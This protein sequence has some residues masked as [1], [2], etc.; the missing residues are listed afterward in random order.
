MNLA[1]D[2][3]HHLS[4]KD[5]NANSNKSH[6]FDTLVKMFNGNIDS[7]FPN[8][9]KDDIAGSQI[10]LCVDVKKTHMIDGHK[11]IYAKKRKFKLG[12]LEPNKREPQ[13]DPKGAYKIK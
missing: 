11:T 3:S 7:V 10:N 2:R 1:E 8:E 9:N 12:T 4:S 5:L 6:F 13:D